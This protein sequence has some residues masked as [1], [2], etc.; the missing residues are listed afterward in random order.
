MEPEPH[1]GRERRLQAARRARQQP[2]HLQPQLAAELEQPLERL[3]LVAV[4]GDHQGPAG[5]Q[6]GVDPARLAQLG[7]PPRPALGGCQVQAQQGVLAE[8]GLGDRREHPGGDVRRL[9]RER[10]ALEQADRQAAAGSVPGDRQADYSA[11][12]DRDVEG[13]ALR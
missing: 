9:A 7:G 2:L 1:R 13:F 11:A 12:H 4:A 3:G 5:A 6:A 10:A 8:L